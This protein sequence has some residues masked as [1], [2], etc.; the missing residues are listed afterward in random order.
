MKRAPASRAASTARPLWVTTVTRSASPAAAA[1]SVIRR[2]RSSTVNTPPGFSWLCM[3]ATTTTPLSGEVKSSADCS[4]T[5]RCPRWI[6]SKL[7]G[8]STVVMV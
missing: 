4:I 8:Y 5:S 3:T 7:P 6:G 2:T 1:L